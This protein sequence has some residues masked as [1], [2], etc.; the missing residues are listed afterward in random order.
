M[1]STIDIS[2]SQPELAK[3]RVLERGFFVAPLLFFAPARTARLGG[4]FGVERMLPREG[5]AVEHRVEG[6][7]GKPRVMAPA[8]VVPGDAPQLAHQ[9]ETHL[10]HEQ[11]SRPEPAAL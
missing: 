4:D 2:R 6:V 3:P 10:V 11:G 5:E 8:L 7:V 9:A 1:A